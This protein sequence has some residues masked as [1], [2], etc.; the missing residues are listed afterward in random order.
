VKRHEIGVA[1]DNQISVAVDRQLQKFV[2]ARIAA[3]DDPLDDG[4][5]FGS[6]QHLRQIGAEAGSCHGRDMRPRQHAQNFV[7]GGCGFEQTTVPVN[8]ADDQER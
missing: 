7:L 1:G 8:P 5:R 3:R 4:D 6:D 2:I